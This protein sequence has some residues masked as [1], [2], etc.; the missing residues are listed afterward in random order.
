MNP[1]KIFVCEFITGG[2]MS[3]QPLP[4]S[5]ALEGDLMLQAL[6]RDLAALP[7]IEL[8]TTR[9]QRLPPLPEIVQVEA[10]ANGADAWAVWRRC[11][12]QSEA[13]WPIAPETDG[14]LERLSQLV[15]DQ[16]RVLLGCRPEVVA[17][18]ASKLAT[19]RHL[20]RA[21][22]SVVPTVPLGAAIPPSSHGWVVKPD[23]GVGGAG[24]YFADMD[25]LFAGRG[26]QTG[27]NAVIQPYVPGIPA[28][29]SMLCD[30]GQI[31]L[32]ACNQQLVKVD[33][34]GICF[35]GVVVNGLGGPR[36]AFELIA[37]QV[38]TAIPG[39]W[40][41]VGVDLVLTEAGPVIIEINPRLTTAYAGLAE[42][43]GRNPATLILDLTQGVIPSK[44]TIPENRAV[45]VL[46]P[47]QANRLM[48]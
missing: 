15:L 32:L 24:H 44:M 27:G 47:T 10:V 45:E 13:V 11:I 41:Y 20:A 1:R 38:A 21:G 29:L 26:Q 40:G 14:V 9:D 16:Q 4:A 37:Q 22:L 42:A 12:D 31:C 19:A 43:I 33:E 5:L 35:T 23:D 2:G 25:T 36:Q 28:S 6:L 30:R 7:D 39:L 8:L 48:A 46:L 18:A 3:G 17:L 34:A